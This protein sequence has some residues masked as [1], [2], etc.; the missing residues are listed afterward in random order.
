MA[1]FTIEMLPA[2]DGDALLVEWGDD[3]GS[4]RLLVDGG[5][6][7]ARLNESLAA[8]FARRGPDQHHFE[9][10]VS[11]HMDADHIAG[12]LGLFGEPPTTFSC[13]EIWFNAFRHLPPND[14]LG[15]KQSDRLEQLVASYVDTHPGTSWNETFGQGG[16]IVLPDPPADDTVSPPPP[17]TTI[18]GMTITLL[19]PR[20][21]RLHA[22][23]AEWPD[24]VKRARLDLPPEGN[25]PVGTVDTPE[26]DVLGFDADQGVEP[27]E[28]A[29]RPYERDK[30]APNGSSIAFLAEFA[31]RRVLFGADAHAEVLE[32][33][34]RRWQPQGA[35]HLD[36]VKL[37]HHGSEKN[38]SPALLGMLD[39]PTWL[40]STNGSLHHHPDRRAIARLITRHVPTHLVF[41]YLS[42][43]TAEWARPSLQ[44][45]YDFT[46]V[47]PLEPTLG[48]RY[49]VLNGTATPLA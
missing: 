10:V 20:L 7:G 5:R 28:L 13:G 43:E 24:A 2:N 41:N 19:S 12:L 22:A 48:I 37:S 36:A 35:I 32:D 17:S 9:L 44:L 21:D 47:H 26:D 25:I 1:H 30:T 33:T 23:A 39:C 6:G 34:L 29:M 11:T 18:H 3:S 4:F 14:V 31:G 45:E 8:A 16:A 38:L 27:R 49:D 42:A 15:W 46:A 40:V